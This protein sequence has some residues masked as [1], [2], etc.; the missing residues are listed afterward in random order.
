MSAAVDSMGRSLVK[1]CPGCHKTISRTI[2]TCDCGHRFWR[3]GKV[4]AIRSEAPKKPGRKPREQFA[5]SPEV[6]SDAERQLLALVE[7][8]PPVTTVPQP[9]HREPPALDP[10][11]YCQGTSSGG[12][13]ICWPGFDI[14]FTL[15]REEA[16]TIRKALT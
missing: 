11:F 2:V 15:T 7:A 13:I 1:E 6:A 16:S 5:V 10:R 12:L 8:K 3:H 4:G 14:R 9:D